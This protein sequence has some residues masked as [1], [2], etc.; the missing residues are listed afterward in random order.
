MK[1]EWSVDP[2]EFA[3]YATGLP[4]ARLQYVID[5]VEDLPP[6]LKA[7]I[8]A[9]FWEGLSHPKAIESLGI[10]PATFYRRFKEARERLQLVLGADPVGE[11]SAAG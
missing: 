4:Q 10:S 11:V 3:N 2:G 1:K 9:L 7:V 6:D 8:D 5:A